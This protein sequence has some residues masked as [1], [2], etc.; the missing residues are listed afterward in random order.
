MS[1]IYLYLLVHD[2]LQTTTQAEGTFYCSTTPAG[3]LVIHVDF[4]VTPTST[5]AVIYLELSYHCAPPTS[6]VF[7]IKKFFANKSIKMNEPMS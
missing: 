3:N 6:I 4:L 7:C 1:G 5:V 2:S